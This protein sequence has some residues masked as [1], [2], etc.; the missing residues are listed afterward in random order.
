[1]K[2]LYHRIFIKNYKKRISP[3]PKLENQF[4]E[5][6]EKFIKNPNDVSLKD[7][8]LI[9]KKK[10]FRSFSISGDIRVI[11]LIV[12]DSVWLYDVGIHNQVY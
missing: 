2:I 1:M 12:G 8:K 10:N 9:G 4:K 7:H 5:Q 6:L 3:Y 11:Y